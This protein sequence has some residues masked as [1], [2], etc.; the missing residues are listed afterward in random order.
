MYVVGW[1][2]AAH[3]GSMRTHFL[4]R[5]QSS[6]ANSPEDHSNMRLPKDT[7]TA[8]TRLNSTTDISSTLLYQYFRSRAK[9]LTILDVRT[10]IFSGLHTEC[11]GFR[12]GLPNDIAVL[13]RRKLRERPASRHFHG[14]IS[15]QQNVRVY[16]TRI[17][18][19]LYK[20]F[21]CQVPSEAELCILCEEVPTYFAALVGFCV[22]SHVNRKTT[23][24]YL[25]R[26][27]QHFTDNWT[28]NW[29]MMASKIVPYVCTRAWIVLCPYREGRNWIEDLLDYR[30]SYTGSPAGWSFCSVSFVRSNEGLTLETMRQ[31][32]PLSRRPLPSSTP[33]WYT[34]LSSAPRRR[35]YLV[36]LRAG[37]T[38]KLL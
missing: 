37:I 7:Y 33:S 17:L 6:G 22:R 20:A 2:I 31:L 38:L 12:V 28:M 35:S 11:S 4:R 9:L 25:E 19:C 3:A 18:P 34:S 15:A 24:F 1:A 27:I 8:P 29:I 5:K 14:L 36:L 23:Y 32:L 30:Q 26:I 16:G 10:R 13:P 21:I